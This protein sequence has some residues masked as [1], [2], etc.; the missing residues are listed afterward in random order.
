MI[1][2]GEDLGIVEFNETARINRG[3]T[4]ISSQTR[5]SLIEGIPVKADGTTSIGGGRLGCSSLIFSYI[6]EH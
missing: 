3:M 1:R 5:Q 2:D 4:R 6:A